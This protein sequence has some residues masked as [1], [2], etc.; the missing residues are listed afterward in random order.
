MRSSQHSTV[1]RASVVSKPAQCAPSLRPG[2][3]CRARSRGPATRAG[4]TRVSRPLAERLRDAGG[5]RM[6]AAAAP[7]LAMDL[8]NGLRRLKLATMR[9]QAPEVLQTA[10]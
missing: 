6:I 10:V 5:E 3:A 9:E 1:P 8:V 4:T 2:E 7:P